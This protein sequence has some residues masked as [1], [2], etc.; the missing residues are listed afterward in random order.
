MIQRNRSANWKRGEDDLAEQKNR[1]KK[2]E[3]K[4][5]RWV[6]ETLWKKSDRQRQ[7]PYDFTYVWN[8]KINQQTEQNRNRILDAEKKPQF[9]SLLCYSYG[10]W[11][12]LDESLNLRYWFLPHEMELRILAGLFELN[13]IVTFFVI[14]SHTSG[15]LN[16]F[17][18]KWDPGISALKLPG[19]SCIGPKLRSTDSWGFISR[20]TGFKHFIHAIFTHF[21]WQFT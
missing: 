18:W 5:L 14:P 16:H 10:K 9:E 4:N 2:K 20:Q 17:L 6:W 15:W 3:L 21:D 12:L 7:I 11:I 13:K 8:I 19:Y 1:K